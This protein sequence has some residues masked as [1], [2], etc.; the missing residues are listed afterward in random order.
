MQRLIQPG[1]DLIA[2]GGARGKRHQA[3]V[4]RMI[5]VCSSV[6]ALHAVRPDIQIHLDRIEAA[7]RPPAV[8]GLPVERDLPQAAQESAELLKSQMVCSKC[9]GAAA[10]CV[11]AV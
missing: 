10:L 6:Q 8:F 1:M 5:V 7:R 3:M 2:D 4:E 11:E 9:A